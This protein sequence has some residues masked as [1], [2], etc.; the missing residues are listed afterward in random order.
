MNIIHPILIILLYS[1]F[2]ISQS[3]LVLTYHVNSKFVAADKLADKFPPKVFYE[4]V[5][6]Y[7]SNRSIYELT[8][9]NGY[10]R[11]QYKTTVDNDNQPVNTIYFRS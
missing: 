9:S 7:E 2:G 8:Y 4:L 6:K 10:S 3:N 5:E 11:F 1:T